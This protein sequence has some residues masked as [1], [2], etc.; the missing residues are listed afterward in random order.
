MENGH[1]LIFGLDLRSIDMSQI[2]EGG[3]VDATVKG[4]VI[5]ELDAQKNV[6]F[7]WNSFDH[8]QITDCYKDLTASSIDYVHPNS[9]EIDAE[10]NILLVARAMNELTKIN[11]LTGEII[12]RL[13]GKNNQF[14]F[15]DTA[16]MF[17]MPHSFSLLSNGHYTLFDNGN[18]RDP[19]Y[20]RG[21]EYVIDEENM[22]IDMVWEFDADKTVFARSGGSI[23]RLP[24]GNSLHCY[25][26][27]VSN[28]S[29][30]EARPDGSIAWRLGFDDP[31]IRAGNAVKQAWLT[32]LFSTNTNTVNFGQWD[33]YTQSVYILRVKNES[34]KELEITGYHNH[35]N[36]F[37][38]EDNIFP[39]TLAPG[40]EKSMNLFYYPYD[41]ES[42]EVN[43]VL[44]LNSDINTDTLVRRVAVQVDLTGTKIVTS[45]NSNIQEN[46]KIFP[47]PAGD[48]L[49]IKMPTSFTGELRL[50]SPT[51]A[52]VYRDL[53][54][55][56][57]EIIDLSSLEKGIYIIEFLD[58]SGKKLF[59]EK[60]VKGD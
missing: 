42:E 3:Q 55:G 54:N 47:N 5:Q 11:R 37:T 2:V 17:S 28:P 57:N 14:D 29:L 38:I 58:D 32:T 51:G 35:T 21:V 48:K 24:S 49:S 18:D 56:D 30:I 52:L 20:S 22:T 8:Y 6:V 43:D 41:I 9:L 46:F 44:T 15:V 31:G 23:Q 59:T 60:L 40:E 45:F 34:Q 27:Q 19:A 4:C 7:E 12:W 13:G 39:M 16:M 50:Y 10:G 33:G 36:A 53:I 25:G 26:G 1:F